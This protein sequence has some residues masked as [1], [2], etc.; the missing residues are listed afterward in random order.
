MAG[1]S[2]K[3]F[4]QIYDQGIRVS[5]RLC[6]A[7]GD[8]GTG[9]L[10]FATAKA[11]GNKPRRNRARR[12]F[13]AAFDRDLRILEGLDVVIQISA[14]GADAPFEEIVADLRNVL[15]TLAKRWANE[16]ESS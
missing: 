6:R 11:I 3:R 12:R 9:K 5:G 1:P 8:R 2:K 7:L 13:R 14:A 10:G 15:N 4:E 16:S